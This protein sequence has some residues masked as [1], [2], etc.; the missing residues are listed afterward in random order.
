MKYKNIQTPVLLLFSVLFW[1]GCKHDTN[2]DALPEIKFSEI[3]GILSGSCG[4]SN[5]HGDNAQEFSLIGYDNVINNGDVKAGKADDSKLYEVITAS[6]N[7]IMPPSPRSP[8]SDD[9]IKKIYIWI[10]QGAKNN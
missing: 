10:E 5:C 2:L 1:F 8:L 3:Q 7:N 6:G 9:N 4:S